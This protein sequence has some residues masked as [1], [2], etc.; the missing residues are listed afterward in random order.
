MARL[1]S[2]LASTARALA[3]REVS[4]AS[5]QEQ[6]AGLQQ[7]LTV[8]KSRRNEALLKL[9]LELTRREYDIARGGAKP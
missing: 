1:R 3:E 6:I 7:D 2:Q 9:E 5:A 4:L 8:A